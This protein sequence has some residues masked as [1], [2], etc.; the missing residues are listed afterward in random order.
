MR[1]IRAEAAVEEV[2]Q[3]I[4]KKEEKDIRKGMKEQE[5]QSKNEFFEAVAG[6]SVPVL[7][8]G[9]KDKM[10]TLTPPEK[11]RKLIDEV[12]EAKKEE[13]EAKAAKE[14]AEVDVLDWM[15]IQ[16]DA[17]GFSQN[18]QKSYRIQGIK[19]MVTYVSSDKF[20]KINPDDITV[21]KEAFGKKFE[22]M[23]QKKLTITVLDSVINGPNCQELQTELL[24]RIGKENFPKFFKAETVYLPADEFDRK[25]YSF[26]KKIVE[27]VRNLVRQA[28]SSLK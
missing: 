7:K 8:T 3:T 28:K 17:D 14:T 22:E 19:E 11:I 18:F 16:Q 2:P 21:L 9:H 27:Q 26:S 12:V 10:V 20:S 13:K 15:Q 4:T 5:L 24:E 6:A 25:L 1:K 23:I